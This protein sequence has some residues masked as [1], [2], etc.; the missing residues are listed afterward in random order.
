MRRD[1]FVTVPA[2]I[3]SVFLF[4]FR[5]NSAEMCGCIH[6][7]IK[8]GYSGEEAFYGFPVPF[9]P[10][11]VPNAEFQFAVGHDGNTEILPCMGRNSSGAGCVRMPDAEDDDIRI[12]HI[13]LRA[14]PRHSESLPVC[15][16]PG[17]HR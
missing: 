16:Q 2:H 4:Q 9:R 7:E 5:Q 14:P 8:N 1:H 15:R 17:N 11:A 6:V 12:K 3:I 10:A 13:H